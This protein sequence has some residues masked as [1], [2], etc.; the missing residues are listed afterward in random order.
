MFSV[1]LGALGVRQAVLDAGVPSLAQLV[2]TDLVHV[3]LELLLELREVLALRGLSPPHAGRWRSG[4]SWPAPPGTGPG[5]KA[6]EH[7]R[8]AAE[9]QE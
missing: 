4:R 5:G 1:T 6:G 7:D 8:R 3:D 2:E 9:G